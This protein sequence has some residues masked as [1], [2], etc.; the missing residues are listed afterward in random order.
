MYAVRQVISYLWTSS[1]WIDE[2]GYRC[3]AIP[4]VGSWIGSAL[5]YGASYLRN[6]A[7]SLYDFDSWVEDLNSTANA[8]YSNALTAYNYATGT[9][10]SMAQNALNRANEAYTYAAGTVLS[11]A[12]NA[13]NRANEAYAYASGYLLSRVDDALAQAAA[14]RQYAENAIASIGIQDAVIGVVEGSIGYLIGK[15]FDFLAA[16]WMSF[17]DSFAWLVSQLIGLVTDNMPS[18]ASLLW[19]AVEAL[20]RNIHKEG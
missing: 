20:L 12:Q 2:A 11:L 18:F 7:G 8:A 15:M 1:D 16:N 13:L 19:G 3:D 4:A 9:V 17:R 6:A 5:H 14:A 10:L